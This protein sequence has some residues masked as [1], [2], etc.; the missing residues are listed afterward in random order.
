MHKPSNTRLARS[1]RDLCGYFHVH[2]MK[3]VS[4][5]LDVETNRVDNTVG[6]GNGYLH[7]ALVVCVR[8]DLFNSRVLAP[9]AMPRDNA[10]PGV[11]IA[12]TAHDTTANK[13]SSAKHG[14]AVHCAIRQMSFWGDRSVKRGTHRFSR[15]CR[16]VTPVDM[17]RNDVEQNLR[18]RADGLP[19]PFRFIDQRFSF[20]VQ[21][22]RLLDDR[23]CSIEKIDQCLGRWQGF[24]HLL[25][26]CVG[27]T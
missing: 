16:G 7:G 15:L 6:T 21:F 5:V 24:L 10:D 22:F 26:L 18:C 1:S 8:G 13:A 17:M 20:S 27:E 23:S 2:R 19:L 11:R 14:D 12:Q 25:K 3:S 4:S 9:P